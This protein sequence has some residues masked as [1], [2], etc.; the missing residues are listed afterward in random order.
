MSHEYLFWREDGV[1]QHAVFEGAFKMV[2][3][4]H[5]LVKRLGP[6]QVWNFT[7]ND[8][9]WYSSGIQGS[10]ED[11]HN[12]EPYEVHNVDTEIRC[13]MVLLRGAS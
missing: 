12:L 10:E 1:V 8:N 3:A 11:H 7:V 2:T 9:A 4:I 5:D 13:L 6:L